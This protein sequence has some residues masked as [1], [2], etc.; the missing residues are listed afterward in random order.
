M[1]RVRRW[2]VVGLGG[3]VV[4]LSIASA[5]ASTSVGTAMVAST[6]SQ[7]QI[8]LLFSS[9]SPLFGVF[10][11]VTSSSQGA[12][13]VDLFSTTDFVHF[14]NITPPGPPSEN[15]SI[16]EFTS[17]SFPTPADG[18][19]AESNEDGSDGYL[20]H[21]TDGGATW[22]ETRQLWAGSGGLAKISFLSA[23]DGWLAAG[24]PGDGTVI[25]S[26]TTDGGITW[27]TLLGS[28]AFFTELSDDLPSFSSPTVG[29]GVIASPGFAVSSPPHLPPRLLV[30]TDEVK[31][32]TDGG[33]SWSERS[34][35][36][37]DRGVRFFDEPSFF[38]PRGVL[39]VTVTPRATGNLGTATVDFD[40]TVDGG[41]T[42]MSSTKLRTTAQPRLDLQGASAS[43]LP[44]VSEVALRTWWVLA[45]APSGAIRVSRTIDGGR[46][47]TT[48]T[49]SSLPRAPVAADAAG[50]VTAPASIQA[51]NATLAVAMVWTNPGSVPASY[52]TSD[53]G[54]HWSHVTNLG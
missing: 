14:T 8:S 49:S 24:D 30:G 41:T 21:T 10:E 4:L 50:G 19:V 25:L 29:I 53:G 13:S 7:A 52:I 18:W 17:A 42:W 3:A 11:D 15:G 40:S 48:H 38:G 23:S 27:K 37:A 43:G 36:V 45:V 6:N 1:R 51:V 33:A 47:W 35:P 32:S 34:V 12:P 22:H 9:S 5:A 16:G 26:A 44:S 54:S 46:H 31:L 20:L 2:R 39:A 28:G